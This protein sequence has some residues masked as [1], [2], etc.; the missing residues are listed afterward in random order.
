MTLSD[1]PRTHTEV[2]RNWIDGRWFDVGA[3]SDSCDPA[4]G[5]IIGRY[6]DAG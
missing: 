3:I 2:A 1:S 4:T 6:A 5:E